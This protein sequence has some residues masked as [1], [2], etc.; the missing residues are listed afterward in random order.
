MKI[1]IMGYSGSGKSTLAGK[2]AAHHACDAFHFDA[3]QFLP[4]WEV[5]DFDEKMQMSKEFLDTHDSW[6]IDGTYSR[7]HL[8]RRLEEADLVILMLFNRFNSLYRVTKRYFMYKNKT[9]PDMA[10]GCNEKLDWEFV[11][12]VLRDGRKKKTKDLFQRIQ[13]DY[14]D[15]VVVLKNQRQLDKWSKEYGLPRLH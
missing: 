1:A 15:K 8:E 6:V 7:F 13:T 14:A 2:L 3:I 4:G 10:E 12:W 11:K 5:R 9:R